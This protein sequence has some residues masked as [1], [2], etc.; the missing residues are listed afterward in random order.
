MKMTTKRAHEL[1][2]VLYLDATEGITKGW[3]ERLIEALERVIELETGIEVDPKLRKRFIN[4]TKILRRKRQIKNALI[5]L[6]SVL[7]VIAGY[8]I[9]KL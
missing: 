6:T 1:L 5:F 3:S 7:A 4:Y 8:L 9:S 2:S